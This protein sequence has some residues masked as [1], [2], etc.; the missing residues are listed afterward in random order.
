MD[1]DIN[2]IRPLTGGRYAVEFDFRCNPVAAVDLGI[3]SW[4]QIESFDSDSIYVAGNEIIWGVTTTDTAMY[5]CL[6]TLPY[7]G[8]TPFQDSLGGAFWSKIDSLLHVEVSSFQID[9]DLLLPVRMTA[10]IDYDTSQVNRP[11]IINAFWTDEAG[12]IH[13][14]PTT[15][16]AFFMPFTGGEVLVSSS[17]DTWDF[18]WDQNTFDNNVCYTDTM[19]VSAWV[20][21]Y[22]GERIPDAPLMLSTTGGQL[23]SNTPFRTT[24]ESGHASWDIK[25]GSS[26]VTPIFSETCSDLSC[27][28]CAYT[29]FTA[30]VNVSLTQPPVTPSNQFEIALTRSGG[31]CDVCPGYGAGCQ[32]PFAWN[33]DP[34]AISDDGS[35]LVKGDINGD[36][37]VDILDI[38]LLLEAIFVP[39]IC[40]GYAH[41]AGDLNIDNELSVFDLVMMIE[42]IFDPDIQE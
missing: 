19:V 14:F 9:E 1:Y 35:C 29:A 26:L 40:A 31:E 24:N 11:Y 17:H 33:Y 25:Y 32:D 39:E 10:T 36:L 15:H 27:D 20:T 22:F 2:S 8:I 3:T 16:P 5:Q 13:V 18:T 30:Y 28:G 38:T 23:L 42:N 6:A 37:S 12:L 21:G 4:P 41:W 34:T 7:E